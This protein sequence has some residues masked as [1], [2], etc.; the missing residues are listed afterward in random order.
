LRQF[1]KWLSEDR[2]GLLTAGGDMAGKGPLILLT[3]DD[4]IASEGLAAIE[5]QLRDLGVLYVVAPDRERNANSHLITLN[6]PIYVRQEGKNRFSTS[7]SPSDCVNLGVNRLLP[8]KPDL[9]VSGINNGGNLAGDITYS[10]TV[11][12]ALEG[13]LLGIP[14]MALSLVSRDPRFYAASAR[15]GRD[16]ARWVLVNGLPP[17]VFLNVNFPDLVDGYPGRIRWTRMGRKFYGDFLEEGTDEQGRPCYRYGRDALNYDPED[18]AD[19]DWRAVEQG[20]VSVTPLRLNSTDEDALHSLKA[21]VDGD[22]HVGQSGVV[23]A[24]EEDG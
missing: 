17:E 23:S 7:G 20:Y 13:R 4:G 3:N 14:S 24:P 22:V 16:L 19:A 1:A 21:T 18:D 6:G 9:V 10:G 12:A 8:A 5:E 15:L 11:G 2:L